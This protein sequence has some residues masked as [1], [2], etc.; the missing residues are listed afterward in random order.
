MSETASEVFLE[1]VESEENFW[2]WISEVE[3]IEE[4]NLFGGA[5]R[6]EK[7]TLGGLI[8]GVFSLRPLDLQQRF[9]DN[10]VIAVTI[11]EQE[12]YWRW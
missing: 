3:I 11:G 6:W 5:Y 9:L 8:T 4:E 10:W 7:S 2:R 1:T 12:E